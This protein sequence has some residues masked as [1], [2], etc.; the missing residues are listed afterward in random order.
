MTDIISRNELDRKKPALDLKVLYLLIL[1]T[2]IVK[3]V[4]AMMIET[5]GDGIKMWFHIKQLYYGLPFPLTHQSVRFGLILPAY[6][7]MKIFGTHPFLYYVIP[8]IFSIIQVIFL[9]KIGLALASRNVAFFSCILFN[10]FPW[11]VITGLQMFPGY[12]A[13]TYILISIYL[14]IKFKREGEKNILL[15]LLSGLF[16][17]FA[18]GSKETVLFFLPGYFISLWLMTGKFR[19]LILFGSVP[20]LLFIGET[21]IYKFIFG[22]PLGR[23]SIIKQSHFE[24]AQMYPM[25]SFFSL[26]GRF[27]KMALYWKV[28][29]Y[30]YFA[31]TAFLFV[32]SMKKEIRH[33]IIITFSFVFFQTF[34]VKSLNPVVPT[35]PFNDR[36]LDLA[37]PGV[38][39]IITYFI[40]DLIPRI[41]NLPGKM[42]HTGTVGGSLKFYTVVTASFSVFVIAVYMIVLSFFP[43]FERGNFFGNH[44]FALAFQYNT[45]L[46]NAYRDGTPIVI[47]K[48]EPKR[49]RVKVDN[50]IKLMG[51]GIP[52]DE[53]C[54]ELGITIEEYTYALNRVD[55]GDYKGYKVFGY[56]FWDG[57]GELAAGQAVYPEI[58]TITRKGK[59]FGVIVD[60]KYRK[61]EFPGNILNDDAQVVE[62][63]VQPFTVYR[64]SLSEFLDKPSPLYL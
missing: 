50:V 26:L 35:Q 63:T 55:A 47:R 41:R 20:L 40:I 19:H 34:S 45:I 15:I 43:N 8:F 58:V 24:V 48:V 39:I 44:P 38:M 52:S 59:P 27:T 49:F 42:K 18:Y 28:V 62:L 12:I 3:I 31:A 5:G 13:S 2:F 17:F 32:T 60:R 4:T 53:A 61:S 30:V 51:K 14:I 57:M 29:F 9:Y 33:I 22:F 25:K 11:S 21:M 56:V 16:F 37:I 1:F 46:K 23:L 54:R 36:H 6:V 10:L 7:I 64:L